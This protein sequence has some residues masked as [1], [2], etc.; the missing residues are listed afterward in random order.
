MLEDTTPNELESSQDEGVEHVQ[1]A[2]SEHETSEGEPQ[3]QQKRPNQP[4]NDDRFDRLI[5]KL[6]ERQ[7]PQQQQQEE[8]PSGRQRKAFPKRE[9]FIGAITNGSVDQV[10]G[11]LNALYDALEDRDTDLAEIDDYRSRREALTGFQAR[12]E[13]QE[14]KTFHKNLTKAVEKHGLASI[15]G[16][17]LSERA[18]TPAVQAACIKLHGLA[19]TL[20]EAHDIEYDEALDMALSMH[21]KSKGRQ[22]AASASQQQQQQQ[23]R[24]NALRLANPAPGRST[25][26][27]QGEKPASRDQLIKQL[28]NIK[29]KRTA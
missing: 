13:A 24:T 15:Y 16:K 20:A 18:S 9:D 2:S 17:S 5:E 12:A 7:Q 25:Q 4:Q 28:K 11:V 1:D 21:P 10:T 27:T 6:S 8:K 14:R 19:N 3:A 26:P 29:S 22:A 23:N